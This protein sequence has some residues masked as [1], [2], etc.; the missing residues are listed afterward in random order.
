MPRAAPTGIRLPYV[1]HTR[2]IRP[3]YPVFP[4]EIER[5]TRRSQAFRRLGPKLRGWPVSRILSRA[6]PPLDDHSS[7]PALADGVQLPTRASR[8]EA[9]LRRYPANRTC[10]AR[11]PYSALL[12]VGLAVPVR[13]P[14]P[15]W[16][17]TPPFH[18]GPACRAVSFSVALS[19]GLPPPGVT[20]HPCFMESGLSSKPA[21]R[22]SA[23]RSSGH[24]RG[25][26]LM[27]PPP[28]RQCRTG[29]PDRRQGRRPPHP[30]APPPPAGTATETPAGSAQGQPP[31][32]RKPLLSQ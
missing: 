4:H 22:R 17:F 15:R 12:R 9:S 26:G 5:L 19:L 23:S 28:P 7:S 20:R 8:A 2:G 16:A 1:R 18:L 11:G 10:P 25:T 14:V 24:P 3:P 30:P 27:P 6:L 13:L 21:F 29:P 32:S 31:D